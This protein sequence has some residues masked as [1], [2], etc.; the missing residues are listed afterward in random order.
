[1]KCP[2]FEQ[3][4]DY[5]DNRLTE[6]ESAPVRSHLATDCQTCA[7]TR[8]WYASVHAITASDESIEPPTW[9]VKRAVRIFETQ[10]NRPR[11][12]ERIGQAVA[13]LVF[14]SFARPAVSGVRSTETTNRQ[15]L[16]RAGDYSIDLQVAPSDQSRADLIGQV[17]REGETTFESVSGLRLEIARSGKPS[18]STVTDAMGEFKISAMD[19]GMYDLRV[20]L[21][22]GSITVPQLPVTQS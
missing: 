8:A 13:S 9:V 5:L 6:A 2:K 11:L 3:L 21:S 14:D 4:V 1:M 10:H 17:L 16:Y 7:E 20:E 12:V 22:E 15:L 18:Y 19:C